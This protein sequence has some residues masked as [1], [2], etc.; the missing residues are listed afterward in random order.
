[1]VVI[2]S[3]VAC[4]DAAV[5]VEE[6]GEA[7]RMGEGRAGLEL[8]SVAGCAGSSDMFRH[9]GGWWLRLLALSHSNFGGCGKI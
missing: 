3:W 7:T 5:W 2:V 1:M 6:N 8:G 4:V 9:L